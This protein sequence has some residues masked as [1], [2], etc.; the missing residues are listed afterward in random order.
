MTCE[1]TTRELDRLANAMESI[2][3]RLEATGDFP[4]KAEYTAIAK[5]TRSYWAAALVEDMKKKEKGE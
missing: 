2:N 4:E 3:R 1:F 5:K